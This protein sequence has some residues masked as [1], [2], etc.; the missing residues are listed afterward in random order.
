MENCILTYC[1]VDRGTTLLLT[2]TD[3]ENFNTDNY[4]AVTTCTES[5]LRISYEMVDD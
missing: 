5:G 4:E 1:L 3:M 2:F